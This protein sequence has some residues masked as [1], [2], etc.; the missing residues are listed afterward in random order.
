MAT[1][2]QDPVYS[3]IHYNKILKMV[4]P[5]CLTMYIRSIKNEMAGN[6]SQACTE[7]HPLIHQVLGDIMCTYDFGN[8]ITG[9]ADLFGLSCS[10]FIQIGSSIAMG[11]I[12]EAWY[13]TIRRI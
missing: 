11:P 12:S 8:I 6:L 2:T 5:T 9:T 13:M 4:I 10:A 3:L 7:N 1:L